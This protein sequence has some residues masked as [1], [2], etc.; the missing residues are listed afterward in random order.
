MSYHI[1][2]TDGIILKRTGFGE[3]NILLHVLTEELGLVIASARSAR[4]AVSKLRP[5]LQ[6][7]AHVSVSVI[8]GKSGWKVTNVAGKSNFFF[9]LQGSSLQKVLARIVSVLLQM[10]PGESPHPEI[11][12]TVCSGFEFLKT[13]SE[14]D[15]SSFEILM[16][17][18]ILYELGYVARNPAVEPFIQNSTIW[19]SSVLQNTSMEKKRLVEIINKALKESQL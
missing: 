12:E 16:V 8:H 10:I 4:L 1:Y 9:D 6:E 7:Y 18:R 15:I 13:I 19:H 3:A 17:L 11:F 14:T 2:T 5:A